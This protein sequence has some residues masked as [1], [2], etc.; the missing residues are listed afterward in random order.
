MVNEVLSNQVPSTF[1]GQFFGFTSTN[2]FDSIVFTAGTQ[3]N[4]VETYNL[5][6]LHFG[7]VPEP[8]SMALLGLG[9]AGLAMSRRKQA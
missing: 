4:G 9:L 5:D 6:N 8:G 1:S 7:T 2:A 3:A